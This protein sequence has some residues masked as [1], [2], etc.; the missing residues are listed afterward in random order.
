MRNSATG[1]RLIAV[2][3]LGLLAFSPPLLSIFDAE[4]LVLGIPLLFLYLFGAWI[5]L[6][7]FIAFILRPSARSHDDRPGGPPP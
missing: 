3:L 4:T 2:F 7:A 5:G 1:D 6:I